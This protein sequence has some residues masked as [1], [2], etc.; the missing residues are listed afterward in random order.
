[1]TASR[2][3]RAGLLAGAS[4]LGLGLASSFAAEAGLIGKRYAGPDFVYDHFTGSDLDQAFGAAAEVNLPV[5]RAFDLNVGYAYADATGDNRDA[6]EKRLTAAL[7][8]HRQTEYGTGYFAGSLGHAWQSSDVLGVSRRDNGAFWGVR[9]GYE[10]AVG[11]R[12]AIDAG[13]GFVDAFDS[14][15]SGQVLSYRVAANHWFSR[16]LAGVA[17]VSYQQ[18]KSAPDAVRYTLGLRWAF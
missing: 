14:K 10:I 15:T 17:G 8:T 2:K 7:L 3:L 9:A 5:A 13:I 18:I 11:A 16:D 4:F 6:L 1:M 12:S